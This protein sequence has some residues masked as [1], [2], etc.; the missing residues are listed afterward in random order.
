MRVPGPGR[1]N[2]QHAVHPEV[3]HRQAPE[4]KGEMTEIAAIEVP[5]LFARRQSPQTPTEIVVSHGG[6]VCIVYQLRPSQR[7][8]LLRALV[9]H[10]LGSHTSDDM[11]TKPFDYPERL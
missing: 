3:V 2:L 8:A 1:N 4:D 5:H 11:W 6:G 9:E 7:R 10:E